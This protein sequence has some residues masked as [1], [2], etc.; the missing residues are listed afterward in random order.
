MLLCVL[1]VLLFCCISY[2]I[3]YVFCILWIQWGIWNKVWIELNFKMNVNM[4]VWLK[5]YQTKFF[6]VELTHLDNVVES[7]IIPACL[8]LNQIKTGLSNLRMIDSPRDVFDLEFEQHKFVEESHKE[9]KNP[10]STKFVPNVK[11]RYEVYSAVNCPCF[12]RSTRILLA[13]C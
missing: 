11:R 12:H 8:R 13:A 10:V 7:W 3:F 2:I 5:S 6:K 9:N 4:L 1:C